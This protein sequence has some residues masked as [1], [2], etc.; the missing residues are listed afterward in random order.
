VVRLLIAIYLVEAG[1]VLIVAPWT[2]FWLRNY[3]ASV[4]P[5][6]AEWMS[7]AYARGAVSGIGIV[8]TVT[9]V[10]ELG[11]AMR[12]RHERAAPAPPV[13]PPTTGQP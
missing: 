11:A 9:G 4:W 7:S 8:T 3:F 1:L 2:D 10:R 13:G 6:L 12:T 5:W